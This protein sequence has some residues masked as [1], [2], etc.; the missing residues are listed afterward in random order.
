MAKR[1]A[2]Y[3]IGLLLLTLGISL[4]IISELG[5]S[6]F[7]AFLVGL[8]R[9]VGLTIGSW[10]VIIGAC[11]VAFNALAQWKRPEILAL[12]TSLVT[13]VGIDFWMYLL[14][15]NI[16]P[17]TWY[18]QVGLL[19]TGL[20]LSGL[21]I[22]TYLQSKFA[23]IPIDR[24]MFVVKDLTGFTLTYSRAIISIVLVILAFF[25]NGPIGIG[26]VLNAFFMGAMISFFTPVMAQAINKAKLNHEV[27]SS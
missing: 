23:P 19:F 15:S 26:T 14:K 7:D 10:E 3:I 8:Y 18:E 6:P 20:V 9:T 21:G 12:L 16:F 13:G 5:T 1:F 17:S 2:I 22:A 27:L 24:M 25:F 4:V 11:I